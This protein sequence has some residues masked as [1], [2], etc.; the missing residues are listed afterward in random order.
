M[1]RH[2]G[3]T[4]ADGV[5]IASVWLAGQAAETVDQDAVVGD[6]PCFKAVP[7]S[8]L[9][10]PMDVGLKNRVKTVRMFVPLVGG[11][12]IVAEQGCGSGHRQAGTPGL[13]WSCG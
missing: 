10:L 13:R 8:P 1:L 4:P 5:G 2:I 3:F 12:A 11:A 9:N 6:T 7:V